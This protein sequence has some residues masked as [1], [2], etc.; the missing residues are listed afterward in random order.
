MQSQASGETQKRLKMSDGF[1]LFCRRWSTAGPVEKAVIFLHG[2]EVHSGAFN[3]M[4]PELANDSTEVYGFDRRGFGNSKE[5]DLPRGDTHGFDRHLEDINEVV[6]FVHKSQPNKKIFLFGH[7][8]GCAYALWYAA[9]YSKQIDGLILAASP[10]EAGF[11][12]PAGDTLKVA[13]AP[14]IQ[15]HSMYDL[16]DHWPQ[17]FKESEEY[18]LITQ[19]GLCTKEFGLGYLFNV[20]TKLANKMPSHAEKIEKPA[21]LLHGDSDIVALP[22]SSKIIFDK[23]ASKDKTLHMFQGADHWFYQSIIPT[24]STK[25]T[26]EQKRTVSSEVKNWLKTL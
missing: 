5:P 2:I 19:D 14:R 16:I 20:Q 18:L 15:H 17:A 21:L 8:I 24:M 10:L 13:L 26:I 11:K 7:S 22:N 9:N 12:I 4:G 6:E 23:L 25:Y 1:D 3:F